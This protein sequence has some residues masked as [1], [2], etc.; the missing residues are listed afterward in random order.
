MAKQ[1]IKLH[2]GLLKHGMSEK[3]AKELWNL[4]EPFAAYGF[5]KA[6]AAS[7]GMVAYQTAYMKANF[8][9]E[10]MTA[11]MTAESGD[12]EKIA[13]AVKEC[14]RMGIAVL[15][16]DINESLK[17]FTFISDTQIRFGLLV[18]KNLGEEVVESIIAQ[19]KAQ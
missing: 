17:D 10:Y 6:H 9:A 18:I 4:I 12:L 19:R 8:P 5:G 16:P 13:E 15:P 11:L 1:K 14:T 2:E 3:K 7:Y